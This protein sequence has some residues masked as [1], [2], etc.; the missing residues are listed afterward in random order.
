MEPITLRL[1][2]DELEKIDAELEELGHSNRS[3]YLRWIIR[4]RPAVDPTTAQSLDERIT[5]IE[6]RLDDADL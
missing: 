4:N 2:E 3:D 1:E 6:Q 5:R